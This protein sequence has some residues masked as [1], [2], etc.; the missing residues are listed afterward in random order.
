VL[1]AAQQAGVSDSTIV[2]GRISPRSHPVF[3]PIAAVRAS[4][5]DA[6]IA[7]VNAAGGVHGR[8]IV[9]K[10]KDD[11][12]SSDRADEG[13]RSLIQEDRVFALLGAWGSPTLPVAVRTAEASKVPLVG[14]MSLADDGRQG[15]HRYVFPVRMS[16]ATEVSGSV[17]HQVTVGLRRF[18]VLHSVEAYGPDGGQAFS[19]AVRAQGFD[20]VATI[21]FSMKDDPAD[22]AKRLHAAQ[23]QAILLSALPKPFAGVLKSYRS[24][25]GSA[26]VVGFSV[27]SIDQFRAELGDLASGMVLTQVAPLPSRTAIPLVAEYR[28]A[29]ARYSPGSAPDVQGLEA[30]LEAKVLVEGLR[31]A[32]PALTRE[33][34][35]SA[36]ETLVNVDFGGVAVRYGRA[37]RTGS[38]YVNL[39]MI[40]EKGRLVN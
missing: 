18:A 20:P 25:G 22:V 40:G 17:R 39:V 35:V 32:G 23:P 37:D 36:L 33:K 8:K 15:F 30:Y 12:Y 5:A 16:T 11:A 9:L 14:A 2:I 19:N 13:L 28:D 29:L 6:Y 3:K 38:T 31:R 27:L 34:L 24:M 10:D 26:Q 7:S 21:P 1:G 4:G